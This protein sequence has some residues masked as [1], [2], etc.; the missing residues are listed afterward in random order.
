MKTATPENSVQAAAAAV[1]HDVGNQAARHFAH[2]LQVPLFSL[3]M[4]DV[5]PKFSPVS[6]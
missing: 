3:Q 5:F 1:G 2:F 4:A 6:C